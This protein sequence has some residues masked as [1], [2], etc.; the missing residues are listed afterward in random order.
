MVRFFLLG[1]L[2]EDCAFVDLLSLLD[3]VLDDEMEVESDAAVDIVWAGL[4]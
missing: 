4:P 2:D 1:M 3:F